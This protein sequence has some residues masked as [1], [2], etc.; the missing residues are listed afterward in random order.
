MGRIILG[1][2]AGFIAWSIVWLGSDKTLGSVWSDFGAYSLAAEKA[3]TNG[4]ALESNP[5][6]AAVNLIRSILTSVIAGYIAA[7]VAGEYRRSTMILG[8]VLVLV[9]IAVEYMIWNV[10][11]VWY[12]FLFVLLL[13]PMTVFGG[14]LRR[15]N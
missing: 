6:I 14:R 12:H 4:T 9:G 8:V 11:P 3:L 1:V 15:A 10:A 2:I 5:M 13:F 7:L